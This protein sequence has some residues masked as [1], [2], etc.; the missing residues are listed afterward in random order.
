LKERLTVSDAGLAISACVLWSTAF[1]GVKIGLRFADPF[2]FAGIRFI[3]AGLL[4]VPF[5][6]RFSTF[7]RIISSN[8]RT[9]LKVSF[10]Q[11]V[12][13]YGCF[14]VGISIIPGALGAIVIGAAPLFSAIT[15]HFF[16]PADKMTLSKTGSIALGILGVVVISLSREPWSAQGLKQFAGVLLL[17][18]GCI[19]SAIGNVLVAQ[20]EDR[21]PPLILNSAQI[22]LGGLLLFIISIPLEGMPGLYPLPPVFYA[23]LLWLSSLSAIAISIWFYLLKKPGIKVSELNLWKFLIPVGGAIISWAILPDESPELL[24]V[25]GMLCVTISILSYYSSALLRRT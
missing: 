25:I 14:Y 22:F 23:V 11:T 21:V 7:L 8:F 18:L 19:S 12:L 6:G 4:L 1:A 5:C 9:I 10:F 3:L 16:M 24:P 17:I 13:L 2:S 15:A 20:D